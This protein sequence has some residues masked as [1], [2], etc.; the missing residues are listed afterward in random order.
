MFAT[1]VVGIII[2][3]I[4]FI[5]LQVRQRWTA[6]DMNILEYVVESIKESK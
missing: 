4:G 1:T 5:S 2:G 6:D 3:A